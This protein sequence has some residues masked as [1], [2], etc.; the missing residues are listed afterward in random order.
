M[1]ARRRFEDLVDSMGARARREGLSRVE[2]DETPGRPTGSSEAA[3]WRA[4]DGEIHFLWYFIQGSIME[5]ATRA[6]LRRAW[7]MCQRHAFASIAVEAAFRSGFL[8]GPAIL[9]KDVMERAVAAMSLRGPLREPLIARRLRE[10]GPCLMCSLG[11]GP[12]SRGQASTEVLERGRDLEPVRLFALRTMPW[13]R[14]AVCGRCEGIDGVARCRVHLR[15]DLL[16]R[17]AS[18][19]RHQ[20][21]VADVALHLRRY[22]RSFRWELRGTDTEQD[23]AALISAIGWCS[24]WQPWLW[25]SSISDE[26]SAQGRPSIPIA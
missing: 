16:R 13:W 15:Q 4:S 14:P 3:P 12:T 8:H 23:R 24:G 11:Y 9:Y 2:V 6:H 25:L 17:E 22:S 5:A 7:G 1:A 18:L 26:R 21:Q 20:A 19:S 10:A